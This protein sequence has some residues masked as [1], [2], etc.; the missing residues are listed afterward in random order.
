MLKLGPGLHPFFFQF[1]TFDLKKIES[2]LK[3]AELLLQLLQLAWL[4]GLIGL[5][6][7]PVLALLAKLLQ[8]S[9]DLQMHGLELFDFAFAQFPLGFPLFP[10]GK[11][12]AGFLG[13]QAGRF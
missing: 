1:R 3:F 12:G 10:L 2:L 11:L 7:L 13:G 6:F 5:G 9:D 4:N 8:L